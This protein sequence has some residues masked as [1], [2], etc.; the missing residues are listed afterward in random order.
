MRHFHPAGPQEAVLAAVA[1]SAR[2]P[3]RAAPPCCARAFPEGQSPGFGASAT[4]LRPGVPLV[5]P[6]PMPPHTGWHGPEQGPRCPDGP[7]TRPQSALRSARE[8]IDRLAPLTIDN[9]AA[10]ALS[11][12]DRSLVDR[13][14]ASFG[15]WLGRR[16]NATQ[17]RVATPQHA[18]ETAKTAPRC[19][20]EGH[21]Q[22]LQGGASGLRAV[23]V[24]AGG[25][26]HWLGKGSPPARLGVTAEVADR[27]VEL[28]R[29]AVPGNIQQALRIAA[30]DTCRRWPTLWTSAL[31]GRTCCRNRDPWLGHHTILKVEADHSRQDRHRNRAHP[32]SDLSLSIRQDPGVYA[33]S[34]RPLSRKLRKSH[35]RPISDSHRGPAL[36]R[37]PGRGGGCPAQRAALPG[38]RPGCWPVGV[39]VGGARPERGGAAPRRAVRQAPPVG[40]LAGPRAESRGRVRDECRR[41]RLMSLE[42]GSQS[43]RANGRRRLL[44]GG[45][46]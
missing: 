15:W 19:A 7:A 4:D 45:H 40:P 21:A 24:R 20:A 36:I 6:A 12:T 3:Q 13:G 2:G 44:M 26:C 5:P 8:A 39:E 43:C 22:G 31:S 30:V 18:Q 17:D 23:G 42:Q 41:G 37:R 16:T 33:A 35:D 10:V 14:H 32:L 46:R 11:L 27:Q 9:E 28:N 38:R 34:R 29:N 1:R 25:A